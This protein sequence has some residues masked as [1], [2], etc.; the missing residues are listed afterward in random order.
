MKTRDLGQFRALHLAAAIGLLS[1]TPS[2]APVQAPGHP[3]VQVPAATALRQNM[4]KLWTDHVV[5][6]RAYVVAAVGDQPDA[7]AAADRLLRNQE[8]I[9]GAIAAYYGKPAGDRLTAL[10][11]EHITIAVDVVKFAKTGNKPSLQQADARW[12]RNGEDIADFLAKANPHWPRA[13]LVQ[14][15]NLHLSTTTDVV[16]ARLGKNWEADVRAYD[17][18]YDH[19]LAMADALSDGIIKQFPD[20]FAAR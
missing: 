4:R 18:V 16:V 1:V 6:T 14:M 10:L 15:M 5:W 20:K 19:I 7:P 3:A 12:R 9:G 17:A 8:H 2:A 13:T 11:K